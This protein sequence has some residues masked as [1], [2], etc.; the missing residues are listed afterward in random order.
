MALTL[1]L[2]VTSC[3]KQILE[4]PSL[5][6][7]YMPK[8]LDID[9]IGTVLPKSPGI[10]IDSSFEDFKSIPVYGGFI[11]DG[12]DSV[13]APAGVLI[14]ESKAAKYVF[15]ES[16]YDRQK[17]ELKYAKHLTREYYKASLAAEKLYQEE[18]LRL[19][20]EAKRT[21]LEKNAPYLGFMAGVL[22]AV[23]TELAVIKIV[24]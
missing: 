15:Y 11:F 13:Q 5:Q 22:S 9:N 12:E 3:S 14:S 2:L 24:D 7:S 23:L 17:I 21:W 8:Y 20:K 19:Q 4:G 16:E 10:I 1:L 18:I 6:Y